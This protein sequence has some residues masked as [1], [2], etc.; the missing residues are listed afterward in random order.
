MLVSIRWLEEMLGTRLE[1]AH[2]KEV[3]PRYGMEIE[4]EARCAPAGILI[5]KITSLEP[6]PRESHL[7]VLGV[8]AGKPLRIVS[9]ATNIK[10][11][12]HVL[13]VPVGGRLAGNEVAAREFSGVLSEGVLVSEQELGLAERSTGVIVVEP[14]VP[15]TDFSGVY[16][17]EVVDVKAFANRPDWLAVSGV[18][19]EIAIALGRRLRVPATKPVALS[20]KEHFPVKI[21]DLRGCPRYTATVLE[22]VTIAD[23]PFAVKW[24]LHCM[25]MKPINNV[26]DATNIVMLQ[27]GQPL[28]PFDLDLLHGGIV[29]R[30]AH[31]GE[32]FK[33][34][35][36]SALHLTTEDLVI[37]DHEGAV[38]LAGVIGSKRAEITPHTTRVLLESACFDPR[39]VAHT[40]RRLGVRTEAAERFERGADIGAVDAAAMKAVVEM[41]RLGCGGR[42]TGYTAR[43]RTGRPVKVSFQLEHLNKFLALNLTAAKVKSLLQ[44]SGLAVTGA[45]TMRVAIPS[46]R[47]DLAIREDVYEEV[48]RLLG[49]MHIPEQPSRNTLVGA[50]LDAR[51]DL[52]RAVKAMFVG[53]GFNEVYTLSLVAG[54]RL[55]ELGLDRHVRIANPL[56]ERFDALRPSLFPGILD[57]VLYNRTRGNAALR[58]FEIGNVLHD[59]EPF[60]SRHLGFVMGGPR[61]P[62]FWDEADTTTD[63]FDAKGMIEALFAF[64]HIPEPAF[65]PGERKGAQ[66]VLLVISA[67]VEVGWLGEIAPRECQGG[68]YYGELDLDELPSHAAARGYVPPGRYPANIRDLSFLVPKEVEV[69]AMM[70]LV[71]KYSG[72][73]LENVSVFDYYQGKNIPADK[74]SVGFR[75]HFRAPDRTLGDAEVDSVVARV[76]AEM[77]K[78]YQAALRSKEVNW[79]N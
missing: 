3:M 72:P 2:L 46:Y 76:V 15:G 29:V 36:G 19:R 35:E 51:H 13:V 30:P 18:A 71:R 62:D 60:Q 40:S 49:Y 39:R 73:A 47:R 77:T 57:C 4:S 50:S 65:K 68:Y 7:V 53:R 41:A 67:G 38:A 26:V 70:A 55:R 23:S 14:A 24:R 1:V 63:Y 27:D 56:N 11:G 12:D 6:H 79:T 5:G 25:G 9:A 59:T 43:G 20:G 74:K 61:Y 42:R 17:D 44:R 48:V 32:Q 58:L 69:P 78:N 31:K 66:D 16:D 10:A 75:L 22:G 21:V 45:K 64:L 34:L 54:K 33:T 8:E 52:E 37:A 28:H